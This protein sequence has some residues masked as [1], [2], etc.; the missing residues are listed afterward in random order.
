[1]D[2]VDPQ[3]QNLTPRHRRLIL[4]AM[5]GSLAMIMMDTTV[6]GVALTTIGDELGLDEI[7]QAWVVNAYLLAMASL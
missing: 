1:M 6:V 5:T 3:L 2:R 4:L 7:A